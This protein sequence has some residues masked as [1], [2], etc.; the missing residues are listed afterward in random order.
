M[1]LAKL[2]AT[3]DRIVKLATADG[4]I[5]DAADFERVARRVAKK[6]SAGGFRMDQRDFDE[7]A[8]DRWIKE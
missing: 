4:P 3:I 2:E 1:T 6:I 5:D 7:E 8:W